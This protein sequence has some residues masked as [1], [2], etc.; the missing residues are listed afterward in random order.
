MITYWIIF[1]IITA[2]SM[3]ICR[4][5]RF[6]FKKYSNTLLQSGMTGIDVIEKMLKEKNIQNIKVV[7]KQGFLTDYYDPQRQ[8]LCL[9]SSVYSGSSIAAAAV[10][11][12]ECGHV[13]QHAIS[14]KWLKF[15]S[16]I[17][18][19]VK[20]GSNWSQIILLLGLILKGTTVSFGDY[21]LMA[22]V[23][24]YAIT[25]IFSLLT[26]HIENNAS[27]RAMRWLDSKFII[28]ENEKKIL[29]DAMFWAAK[30]Y[31][32]SALT[33]FTI[34]I[35]YLTNIFGGKFKYIGVSKLVVVNLKR[36]PN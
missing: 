17:I 4:F 15:Y 31:L 2:I 7:E 23:F 35:Q 5:F 33:S 25:L 9:S 26:L 14:Y 27:I 20:F 28:T 34:I 8:I 3:I 24:L 18:P 29:K 16:T 21:I 30:T 32:I 1:G 6:K 36:V 12:H 19:I 22:G 13:I 10:A 11:I